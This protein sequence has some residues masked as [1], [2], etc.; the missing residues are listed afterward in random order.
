M[1]QQQTLTQ[2][3]ARILDPIRNRP[4][5]VE[6]LPAARVEVDPSYV[7][8]PERKLVVLAVSV[9]A[10]VR[11]RP[12]R[13]SFRQNLIKAHLGARNRVIKD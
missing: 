1:T 8:Q 2:V 4:L 9:L 3:R 5:H 12:R 11:A 13:P 10:R 7:E 6:R